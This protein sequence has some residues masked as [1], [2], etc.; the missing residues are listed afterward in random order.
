MVGLFTQEFWYRLMAS[1]GV[2]IWE[3]LIPGIQLQVVLGWCLRP[4][5]ELL[6]IRAEAPF[7]RRIVIGGTLV[8]VEVL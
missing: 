5:E 6:F 4:E 2:S 8:N 7:N 1:F 3:A